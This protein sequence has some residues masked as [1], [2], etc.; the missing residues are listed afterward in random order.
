VR[1]VVRVEKANNPDSSFMKEHLIQSKF[2]TPLSDV[3]NPPSLM[4]DSILVMS[5]L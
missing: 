2:H 4:A 1:R 3:I 5:A